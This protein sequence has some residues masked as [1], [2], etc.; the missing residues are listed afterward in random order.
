MIKKTSLQAKI[1]IP[2]T[3]CVIF[4]IFILTSVNL[5]QFS[6]T[7]LRLTDELMIET[8]EKYVNKLCLNFSE[9]VSTARALVN[10]LEMLTDESASLTGTRDGI[11]N[12]LVSYVE[13]TDFIF[14]IGIALEPNVIDNDVEY[15][16]SHPNNEFS[17]KEGRFAPYLYHDGDEIRVVRIEDTSYDLERA[18]YYRKPRETR[19]GYVRFHPYA[20]PGTEK[21]IDMVTFSYPILLGE[22]FVG[23]VVFDVDLETIRKK[24]FGDAKIL[25]S[26]LLSLV[27]PNDIVIHHPLREYVG[28]N[29]SEILNPYAIEKIQES[30]EKN[31]IMQFKMR[32]PANGKISKFYS[33]PVKIAGNQDNWA[34]IASIPVVEVDAPVR[35]GVRIS[36]ILSLIVFLFVGF[37]L[38]LIIRVIIK[39][40]NDIIKVTEGISAGDLTV[41]IPENRLKRKDEIGDLSRSFQK[42]EKSVGG[43]IQNIQQVSQKLIMAG[44]SLAANAEETQSQVQNISG[45]IEKVSQQTGMQNNS[46][47]SVSSSVEQIVKNIEALDGVITNQAAAVEQSSSSIE[48]MIGN[49][50]SVNANL[51]KI[52]FEFDSLVSASQN[53]VKKQELV[54]AQVQNIVRFSQ[55]LNDTNNVIANI[56]SQTNLLAMNAAIEA[57]HA[58]DAGKGFA[59][60]ADEI[61]KLA[62]NSST[63]SKAI[64]QQLN[65]IQNG[66]QEVVSSSGESKAAFD[67]I[68]NQIDVINSLVDQVSLAVAEQNQGSKQIL[69]G[70]KTITSVTQEVKSGAAEMRGGSKVILGEMGQLQE[71]SRSVQASMEESSTGVTEIGTAASSVLEVAMETKDRINEVTGELGKF[72]V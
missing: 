60:V 51:E 9:P 22:K 35:M 6:R 18:D 70:L 30:K 5:F 45:N 57:A 12:L 59:V 53:G 32:A 29:I 52:N 54:E 28:K 68:V 20:I 48:E 61:R 27:S 13:G 10:T 38:F 17:T 50:T 16:R 64:E 2:T 1:I 49:L 46:V 62:E 63:Q 69:E 26:G 44:D 14:G 42:M 23:T 25:E 72:K 31:L 67:T 24:G 71:I 33:F 15:L 43:M 21:I 8:G 65:E 56:S 7:V 55:T 37:I 40:F 3:L 58:G 39:M 4:G 36:F 34:L 19:E 11:K 47:A 66:I 41:V